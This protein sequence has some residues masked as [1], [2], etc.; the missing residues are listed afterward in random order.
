MLDCACYTSPAN[1]HA[2]VPGVANVTFCLRYPASR[3]R[4][5]FASTYSAMVTRI[6][7]SLNLYP[8]GLFTFGPVVRLIRSRLIGERGQGGLPSASTF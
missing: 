5:V 2:N 7:L 8:Y 1:L 4:F 3:L 6:F